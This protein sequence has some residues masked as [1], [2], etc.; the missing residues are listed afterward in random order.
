M[1][2]EGKHKFFKDIVRHVRNFKSLPY[3]LALRHQKMVAFHLASPSFFKPSVE[4]DKMKTV[5]VASFPKNVQNSL[6]QMNGKTNTVLEA[7]SI[8]LDGIKYSADMIISVGS[9]SGF[10]DFR[11]IAKIVVI[12]ASIVF[13]CKLVTSWYDV[14]LRAFELCFSHFSSF[15][16]TQLSELN[17][18]FPLSLYKVKGKWFVTL[19]RHIIC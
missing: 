5:M 11:Q 8:R 7:S 12:N 4:I 10:P 17:D 16:V 9:C 19:K 3:T 13:V 6:Y 15:A 2:F 18:V 14:H 1:R